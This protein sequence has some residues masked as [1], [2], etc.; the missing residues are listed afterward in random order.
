MQSDQ[1]QPPNTKPVVPSQ[2]QGTAVSISNIA[3]KVQ[4]VQTPED[5]I[6]ALNSTNGSNS[7]PEPIPQPEVIT[8]TFLKE[9]KD[10][11]SE[12]NT[13]GTDPS[14]E[15]QSEPIQTEGEL[16]KETKEEPVEKLKPTPAESLSDLRKSWQEEKKRAK[17]LEEEK[18]KL[19]KKV[20]E[21]DTGIAVP[22]VLK[23]KDEEIQRLSTYEKLHN[24]KGSQAYRSKFIE[25]MNGHYERLK[26]IAKDYGLPDDV[27]NKA[28]KL[29]NR[30]ELNRF[31]SSHFDEIGALEVKQI[32]G[33]IQKLESE[34]R[35]AEREPEQALTSMQEEHNKIL[36]AQESKRVE[37]ISTKTKNAW[38]SALS[39]IKQ[40][41]KAKELIM[42]DGNTEHNEKI[43]KVI[44]EKASTE[45]GKIIRLLG[46]QGIKDIPEPAAHALAKMT[47]LA[48]A[49]AL[50]I[51]TRD[52]MQAEYEK[53]V[54]NIQRDSLHE[55]PPIGA[56]GVTGNG[57]PPPKAKSMTKEEAADS[58]LSKIGF[59]T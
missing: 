47:L 8:P 17:A 23:K 49:S 2:T 19:A 26:A 50:A 14:S 33:D 58:V 32:V 31:L 53:I 24:L 52:A 25:P 10:S 40:E 34:A 1:A 7:A 9:T 3:E 55:R 6:K 45:Y 37:T 21:Y 59:P 20:E 39:E 30:A 57:T 51:H 5:L 16:N 27:I 4:Q 46:E 54:K 38:V 43:V 11:P 29:T 35:A 36:Q 12:N 44:L 13:D 56:S 15:P 22:E 28:S 48:H 18:T 42:Q 41:G